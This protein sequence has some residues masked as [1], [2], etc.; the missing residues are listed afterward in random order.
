M[1][2]LGQEA[3]GKECVGL[4]GGDSGGRAGEVFFCGGLLVQ[5]AFGRYIQ[6]TKGHFFSRCRRGVL[7]GEGVAGAGDGEA[8]DG[9]VPGV[10]RREVE[11]A[12]EV[13]RMG[14]MKLEGDALVILVFREGLKLHVA[15]QEAG[16]VEGM[17]EQFG[18]R[19]ALGQ[20]AGLE[21]VDIAGCLAAFFQDG[22]VAGPV[23]A[24]ESDGADGCRVQLV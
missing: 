14:D 18:E 19:V 6:D 24:L 11:E 8:F 2:E 9:R 10:M 17:D 7:D 22:L 23:S 1:F 16:I 12:G 3:L 15:E 5:E 21:L 4:E 13:A 20:W